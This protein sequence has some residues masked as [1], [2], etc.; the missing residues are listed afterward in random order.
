MSSEVRDATESETCRISSGGEY[1]GTHNR[2]NETTEGNSPAVPEVR[3]EGVSEEECRRERQ[4][5]TRREA[6]IFGV[7]A[8]YTIW[9]VDTS[10]LQI[11]SAPLVVIAGTHVV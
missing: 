2:G 11:R 1:D 8:C 5:S 7:L 6:T 9:C 3:V 10:G 4:R